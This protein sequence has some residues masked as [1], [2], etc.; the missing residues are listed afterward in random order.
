[1]N[2]VS[3]S[4]SLAAGTTAFGTSGVLKVFGEPDRTV[5]L[6]GDVTLVNGSTK[7]R[8]A[9]SDPVLTTY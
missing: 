2:S 4:N 6:A 9:A 7:A 8:S 3:T 1:M 5:T